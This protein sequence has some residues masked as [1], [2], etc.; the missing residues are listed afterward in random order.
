M[1]TI[2]DFYKEIVGSEPLQAEL[3][4]IQDMDALAL[5]LSKHDCHASAKEFADYIQSQS[6]GELTDDGANAVSGGY[7][8]YF[9]S[10][11]R[12]TFDPSKYKIFG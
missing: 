8:P 6:E 12:A 7:F 3:K 1:K 10:P 4:T 2:E 11:G 5:F 9:I